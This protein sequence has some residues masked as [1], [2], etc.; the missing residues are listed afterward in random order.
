[1]ARSATNRRL[2]C[3]IA[4]APPARRCRKR[5]EDLLSGEG[6]LGSGF[7]RAWPSIHHLR[8]AALPG[9]LAVF[10]LDLGEIGIEH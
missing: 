10:V 9:V 3:S 2:R 5:P 4:S 6:A 7:A 1:M 8:V